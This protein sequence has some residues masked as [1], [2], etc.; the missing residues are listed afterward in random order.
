[1]KTYNLIIIGAGPAGL[2][3]AIYAARYKMNFLVI[4][5]LSG[6][7]LREAYEICNFP[8]YTK[9]KGSELMKKII[10]QVKELGAEVKNEE[11]VKI[12]KKQKDFEIITNKRKYSAKKIIFATG[13]EREK[14]GIA[15][16][17]EF[18]GK[19]LSYCATCDA[20]FYK[21]KTAGVVGGSDAALSAALLLAKFAKKVYIIYRK[22]KF[23]RGDKI[24]IEKVRKN[25]KIEV[26]F[27]SSVTK[28][29][30]KNKLEC[31]E[32]NKKRK[33]ELDGLFVEVGGI[34]N[35]ELA[36]EIGIKT[37]DKQIA[38]DKKQKTSI[39]G[40]FAAGDITNNSLKQI[41]TACAEGAVAAHSAYKE[42]IKEK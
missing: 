34:P 22:D 23:F 13:S 17:K 25:K 32:L 14:L 4:G 1:M 7:M 27:N 28:L 36:E 33:L 37:E 35:I 40:A 39:K 10:E 38:V 9:I 11:A 19:G 41:I 8:S 5:K 2:T 30:G 3:A 29:I 20:G 31:A 6:G 12:K 18:I 42:L 16:E 21:N 15:G 24:W 26:L